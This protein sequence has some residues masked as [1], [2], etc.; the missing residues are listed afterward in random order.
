MNYP[1]NLT[2]MWESGY[3]NHK[4]NSEEEFEMLK[5]DLKRETDAG[6]EGFEIVD[7]SGY[8]LF[9]YGV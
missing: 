2:V 5:E 8:S 6:A 3:S 7:N 1:C 9:S 4:I